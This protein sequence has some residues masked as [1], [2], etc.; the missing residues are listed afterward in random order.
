MKIHALREYF[1]KQFKHAVSASYI[2]QLTGFE[3]EYCCHALDQMTDSSELIC[4]K[5]EDGKKLYKTHVIKQ[6]VMSVEQKA[7]DFLNDKPIDFTWTRMELA[8]YV[9]CYHKS[10]SNWLAALLKQK[11]IHA[12]MQAKDKT[13]TYRRIEFITVKPKMI[14]REHKTER[15]G[16][17]KLGN[18]HAF[19]YGGNPD[20]MRDN[21]YTIS[22]SA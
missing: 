11:I 9:G 1:R 5:N 2:K 13:Y 7:A 17:P 16:P 3:I 18:M 20:A 8:N 19:I 22:E 14:R 4:S 10:L 12:V 6:D 15:I 21:L